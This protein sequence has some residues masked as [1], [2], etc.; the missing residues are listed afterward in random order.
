MHKCRGIRSVGTLM[1]KTV[2]TVLFLALFAATASASAAF[3]SGS[4]NLQYITSLK[5]FTE[6]LQNAAKYIAIAAFFAAGVAIMIGGELTGWVKNMV[7]ACVVVGTIAGAEAI[8]N[9]FFQTTGAT[10]DVIS[11][12]IKANA[13]LDPVLISGT[14]ALDCAALRRVIR[15]RKKNK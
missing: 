1:R 10:I 6:T 2:R 12:A 7:A 15:N 11:A 9:A 3:A 4:S 5:T 8:Y 14:A 13:I